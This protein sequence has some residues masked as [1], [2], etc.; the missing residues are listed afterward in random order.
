MTQANNQK[1]L[2]ETISSLTPEQFKQRSAELTQSQAKLQKQLHL[3]LMPD[4]TAPRPSLF[5][6]KLPPKP[7]VAKLLATAESSMKQAASHITSGDQE[8]AAAEQLKAE[9]AFN[10]LTEV[11]R[12]RIS[13]LTE[14]AQIAGLNMSIGKY[15][16][17]IA[18]LEERQLNLLERTEDA[19]DDKQAIN[20][21]R[22]QEKLT[23]DIAKFRHKVDTWNKEQINP[24]DD[25]PPL[26]N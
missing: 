16:S 10:D 24:S 23:Q 9:T 1:Q 21:A 3:L 13:R 15:A 8:K 26:T 2:R 17:E 18:E 4:I 6:T 11:I 7:A 12:Q 20:L 14:R 22:I 19:E 25:V 5:D